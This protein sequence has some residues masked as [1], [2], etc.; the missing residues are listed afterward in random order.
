[1]GVGW[2]VKAAAK[3]PPPPLELMKVCKGFFNINSSRDVAGLLP[4]VTVVLQSS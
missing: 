2:L 3:S 1:M 4:S